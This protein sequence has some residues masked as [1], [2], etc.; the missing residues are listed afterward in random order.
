M[1]LCPNKSSKEWKDL[2]AGLTEKLAGKSA[3]EIDAVA[4]VAYIL[5]GDGS[6]PA[7][8]EAVVLLTKN[9]KKQ[10]TET[11]KTASKASK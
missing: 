7:V 6:I 3:K 2:S 5:K 4:H 11:V 9:G 8:D 1:S 10:F